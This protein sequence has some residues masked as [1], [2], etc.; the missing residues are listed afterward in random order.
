MKIKGKIKFVSTDKNLFFATLRKRVD[1]YFLQND[2]P[3]TANTAM[4]VKSVVLLL[5]YTL[6]FIV[7]LAFQPA[8]PL[9]LLLWFVMGLGVAGIGMSVMHDANHGA[10]S[11][12]KRVNSLMG[13]TLNLVGGSSFNWKL[14][15]NILHHTYTNVVEMDEDIQDRLVLRFNPHSRVKFFHKIQW[16]YAFLFYGLLTLYWVVAK[17]F[18]QYG[19]FIK[20]GVNANSVKENRKM[21]FKIIAIKVVYF[22]V[23]LV[24]PVALFHIPFLE[25]L[26]GFLLMHFVAGI[27]LTVVFQLAHTVEGTSHP[28]PDANGNI[29]N[30]WA[31]HQMNT[32]VNF[33]RHN[34][35]LSWY[36]GGLNF[37][38]EHHL[39]PRVCHVHYPAISSIVKETA[40]EFNIPYLENE[41][42]GKAVRSHIATLHRFGRLPNINEAIA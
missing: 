15:H 3:K 30:D 41:T 11:A 4:V 21:L 32:T 34:K 36:V 13:N 18:V 33:A 35:L 20:N 17:D 16:V 10:F 1:A 12:S 22:C 23:V 24:L 39:F 28:R 14:Q 6:P 8:F 38:V 9:S 27:I 25:V 37:Q 7:L 42:F 5:T 19:L 40:A 29:E 26:L 2:I 31:I